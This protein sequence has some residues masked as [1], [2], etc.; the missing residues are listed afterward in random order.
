MEK[1]LPLYEMILSP[2]VPGVM[3][4]ALTSDPANEF[5]FVAFSKGTPVT[6]KAD[7]LKRNVTGVL[8]TPDQHIYQNDDQRGEH[9]ITF[10]RDT[11]EQVVKRFSKNLR[12][13]ETNIEHENKI[14]GVYIVESWLSG[15]KSDKAMELGF[16]VKPGTWM[17]TMHAENDDVWQSILDGTFKGFSIEGLFA[18]K[19]VAASKQP[20]QE[21]S[22]EAFLKEMRRPDLTPEEKV[23]Y[24]KKMLLDEEK[25]GNA[26]I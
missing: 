24:A 8:L 17:V 26:G 4:N 18:S 16:S 7:N 10:S 6:K 2:D 12:F 3:M 14:D 15:T 25:P 23:A 9:Y 21:E 19:R 5:K 1:N 20:T 22:I 11:I 13:G